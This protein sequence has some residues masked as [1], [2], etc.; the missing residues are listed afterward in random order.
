MKKFREIIAIK[1]GR[2][3]TNYFLV[4]TAEGEVFVETFYSP[5]KPFVKGSQSET[6]LPEEFDKHI[7]DGKSLRHYVDAKLKEIDR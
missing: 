5:N 2:E 3:D 4:R 6:I 7:I 1:E